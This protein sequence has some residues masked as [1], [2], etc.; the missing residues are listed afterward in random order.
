[1]SLI[2]I[3]EIT[4]E[5]KPACGAPFF[6]KFYRHRERDCSMAARLFDNQFPKP[7]GIMRVRAF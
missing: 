3:G 6:V 1:M 2:D 5:R 4:L 7:F